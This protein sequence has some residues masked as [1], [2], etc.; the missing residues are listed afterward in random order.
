MVPL[1][2]YSATSMYWMPFNLILKK[3]LF[4][5]TYHMPIS[6]WKFLPHSHPQRPPT[7]PGWKTENISCQQ[8]RPSCQQFF[9]WSGYWVTIFVDLKGIRKVQ[10]WSGPQVSMDGRFMNAPESCQL[11]LTMIHVA[12][13]CCWDQQQQTAWD[14]CSFWLPRKLSNGPSFQISLTLTLT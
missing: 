4:L 8:E 12:A 1:N 2:Q 14:S 9:G 5:I 3:D 7:L 10:L 6:P 13:M 11:H